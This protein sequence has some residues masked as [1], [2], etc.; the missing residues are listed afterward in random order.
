MKLSETAVATGIELAER[1]YLPDT[2]V[3]AAIRRLCTLRLE[4]PLHGD[5]DAFFASL[6]DGPIA[7]RPSEAN[8]QHYELPPEFFE[9]VLGPRRKYSCCLW[10]H[11]TSNLAEAE[12]AALAETARRAELEDGQEVLELGCGW[13]SLS[14]WMA[15]HYPT[16]RFVCVS[17][18]HSQ[19]RTIEALAKDRGLNN[20]RVV[21]ADMNEFAP[22]TASL[23]VTTFDR[24]I[25][26]EMFEHMRNYHLLLHRLAAW[27][28][29]EG[30]LFVHIFCHRDFSYPF[31][32]EGHA[33][34]MGRYFFTGGMMPNVDLLRRFNRDLEVTHHWRWNGKHYART[35]LAWLENLDR[36]HARVLA[37]MQRA[38]GLDGG[39]R[40]LQ[41]WRMFFLA[42][43]ELFS[44]DGGEQWF[45]GQYLLEHA[46]ARHTLVRALP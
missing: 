28:Q 42:V 11:Q 3:R 9:L 45:V 24:I 23:E 37:I 7:L 18:S 10:S 19:R 41:R 31:E 34:W 4:N 30:R 13:G 43:A 5:T 12:E 39:K 8:A 26:V 22:A 33:N 29:P 38:Y 46:T 17:N 16:S 6:S 36:N 21:T 40:W 14:L 2:V 20:I 15:E 44:F 1:G 25:S 27:L 35:A 32:A